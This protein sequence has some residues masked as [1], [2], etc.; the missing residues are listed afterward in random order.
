VISFQNSKFH[1]KIMKKYG[2][3][4]RRSYFPNLF[5]KKDCKSS[6]QRM[7]HIS[8]S[9]KFE[10]Y[11]TLFL[12]NFPFSSKKEKQNKSPESP[13]NFKTHNLGRFNAV[14][15]TS[16]SLYLEEGKHKPQNITCC[17]ISPVL[18]SC[19][20]KFQKLTPSEL[21]SINLAFNK[22]INHELKVDNLQPYNLPFLNSTTVK[23]ASPHYPSINSAFPN[24][25]FFNL[26]SFSNNGRVLFFKIID[27]AQ[28]FQNYVNFFSEGKNLFFTHSRKREIS[29]AFHKKVENP[30]NSPIYPSVPILAATGLSREIHNKILSKI[31]ELILSGR[32]S[33]FRLD[34]PTLRSGTE[35]KSLRT[36]ESSLALF[37][38]PSNPEH[39]NW[40]KLV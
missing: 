39:I 20:F 2:K 30:A 28:I 8:F 19:S 18:P 40:N 14:H 35:I 5:F 4:V 11:N 38:R 15:N 32:D 26:K 3:K 10:F 23:L 7:K 13:L 34:V 29:L 22:I 33:L 21:I 24:P 31:K 12:K 37:S 9:I 17:C 6:N 25:K 27:R 36:P 16:M 1:E